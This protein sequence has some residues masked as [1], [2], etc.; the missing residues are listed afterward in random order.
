MFDLVLRLLF[1]LIAY[2]LIQIPKKIQH[3]KL[4]YF[5]NLASIYTCIPSLVYMEEGG[6]V[7][8]GLLEICDLLKVEYG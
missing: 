5:D 7:G 4:R 2:N 8:I 3:D 1:F 6:P